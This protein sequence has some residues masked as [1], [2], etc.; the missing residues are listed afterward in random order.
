MWC[1]CF[2]LRLSTGSRLPGHEANRENDE[3]Q[4]RKSDPDRERPDSAFGFATVFDQEIQ[5][6]TQTDNDA[7]HDKNNEEIDHQI[8]DMPQRKLLQ[9]ESGSLNDVKDS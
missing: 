3:Q 1:G 4:R 7:D 2:C 9:M 8:N 6:E 5:A